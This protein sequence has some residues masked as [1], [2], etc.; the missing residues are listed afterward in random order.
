MKN[1]TTKMDKTKTFSQIVKTNVAVGF[2]VTLIIALSTKLFDKIHN[3]TEDTIA[4]AAIKKTLEQYALEINANSFDANN[5]FAS[6]VEQFF[7]ISKTTP[8]KINL[9]WKQKYNAVFQDTQI[10]FDYSTLEVTVSNENEIQASVEMYSD[11][12]QTQEQKQYSNQRSRYDLKFNSNHKITYLMQQVFN[13]P[14]AN[15]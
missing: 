12:F 4:R 5:Y 6:D 15:N 9:F 11:Y 8:R 10:R 13:E 3:A 7:E 2:V 14:T 1:V